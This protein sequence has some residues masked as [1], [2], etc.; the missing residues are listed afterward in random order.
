[1][2]KVELKTK[3]NESSVEGFLNS[4]EDEEKRADCF[5]VLELM[6]KVTGEEPKMWGPSIVGFGSTHLK[7]DSGR[8]LDW[9]LAGFS[10]RK[11][12]ITLYIM[13]CFERYGD[14]M[15]NLG[16]YKTGKSCLYIKRLD[17]I[18]IKVLG[19]L[20]SSSAENLK[21]A[22]CFRSTNNRLI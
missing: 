19:E 9:M 6:T 16:K 5:R 10:P 13:D 1:M 12:N 7:Y 20:I 8:E 2:A 3:L 18:D 4:V 15:S 14:L 17:D 11:A 21:A 22:R